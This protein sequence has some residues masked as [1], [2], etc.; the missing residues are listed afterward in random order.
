[1][2]P[3][4]DVDKL[5]REAVGGFADMHRDFFDVIEA[6]E[7]PAAV[8]NKLLQVLGALS[9]AFLVLERAEREME[10]LRAR[11]AAPLTPGSPGADDLLDAQARA[12]I[13]EAERHGVDAGAVMRAIE[14]GASFPEAL[15]NALATVEARRISQIKAIARAVLRANIGYCDRLGYGDALGRIEQICGN[16][17][18]EV[19]SQRSEEGKGP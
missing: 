2:A 5:L 1:M 11:A 9:G 10:A 7:L 12:V 18:S 19:R 15:C 14:A 4:I 16:Q 13:A 17:K 8:H 6:A 3:V